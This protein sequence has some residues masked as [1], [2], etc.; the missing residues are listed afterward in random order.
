MQNDDIYYINGIQQVGIGVLDV[1][2]AW[3]FY[4]ECFG[5]DLPI[6]NDEAIAK[7][8]VRYTENEPRKRHAALVLNYQGGGG[9]E[10][11]QHKS[12]VSRPPQFKVMP[13]D[14]GI[15]AIKI[16]VKDVQESYSFLKDRAIQLLTEPP[17]D[18]N[19]LNHFYLYDPFQN[20]IQVVES[21]SWNTDVNLHSG[22]IYGCMIGV[23]NMERSIKFYKEVLGYD[24]ILSDHKGTSNDLDQITNDR[25]SYHRVLLTHSRIKSGAFSKLLGPSEIELVEVLDRIP[26]KIFENRMWGELG[27]IHLCFDVNKI[28]QL[29]NH[30]VKLGYPFTVDS[31]DSFDMGEAAGRFA[32]IE[33]PDGTLIE[34]VETHKIPIL[35]KLGWY[36]DLTKRPVQKPVSKW[37]LRAMALTRVKSVPK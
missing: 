16:K 33:D 12:L 7:L 26:Q 37:L 36:F 9:L 27:F 29:K 28:D 35:K 17:S 34:F 21:K 30:C 1:K 23:K 18:K 31:A 13:G 10:I 24:I 19:G 20:L 15:F 2:E 4:H 3:T 8:M 32:Y 22:G 14:I 5:F 11:W 25:N 6:F